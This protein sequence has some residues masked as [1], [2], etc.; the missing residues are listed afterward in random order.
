MASIP[1]PLSNRMSVNVATREARRLSPRALARWIAVLTLLT[2]IGGIYSLEFVGHR[3]IVWK[4]AAATAA[5]IVAHQDLYLSALTVF[6][7][8]MA[9]SVA[10]TGLFYLLLKPAGPALSLVALLLG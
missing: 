3:L 9:I 7:V 5:N 1:H 10:T 2:I 6:L 8:E 4:D